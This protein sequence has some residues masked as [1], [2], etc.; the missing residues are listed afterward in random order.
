M[1]S[2]SG[3][4]KENVEK[5]YVKSVFLDQLFC[6]LLALVPFV[7][8]IIGKE[9][10]RIFIKNIFAGYF[11]LIIIL[12]F[13]SDLAFRNRSLGKTLFRIQILTNENTKNV[14]IRG[15]LKRRLKE[16]FLNPLEWRNALLKTQKIDFFSDTHI[17]G[18]AKGK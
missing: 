8:F 6:F 7:I 9:P 15:I 18:W 17:S 1:N 10:I 4:K 13:F 11:I 2:S 16:L 3:S 12:Y 5:K 14:P